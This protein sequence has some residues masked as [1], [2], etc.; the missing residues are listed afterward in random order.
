MAPKSSWADRWDFLQVVESRV[1]DTGIRVCGT[2]LVL[3]LKLAQF[4]EWVLGRLILGVDGI[5]RKAGTLKGIEGKRRFA[6]ALTSCLPCQAL[7]LHCDAPVSCC[8]A[9]EPANYRMKLLYIMSRNKPFL[10]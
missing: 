6:T 8:P 7:F 9:L 1:C 5:P 4:R 10:L 2:K 3:L